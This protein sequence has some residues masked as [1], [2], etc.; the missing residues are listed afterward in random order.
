MTFLVILFPF[1]TSCY[2]S[3][4]S[5]MDN[6]VKVMCHNNEPIVYF[7]IHNYDT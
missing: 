7:T 5:V 1:I 4:I 3:I 2:S 6:G